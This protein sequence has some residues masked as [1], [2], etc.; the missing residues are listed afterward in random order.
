MGTVGKAVEIGKSN[1]IAE[2]NA[3]SIQ[4]AR[5]GLEVLAAHRSMHGDYLFQTIQG[6]SR[7]IREGL[8]PRELVAVDYMNRREGNHKACATHDFCDASRAM[9]ESISVV[10]S[11]ANGDDMFF[12]PSLMAEEGPGASFGRMLWNEGWKTVRESGYSRLATGLRQV[13][14]ENFSNVAM[15]LMKLPEATSQAF[16]R[17]P[18]WPLGFEGYAGFDELADFAASRLSFLVNDFKEFAAA[19]SVAVDSGDRDAVMNLL[20]AFELDHRDEQAP[21]PFR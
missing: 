2:R 11:S 4:A 3:W 19:V 14:A 10:L 5:V 15:V 1:V 17:Y 16:E 7:R 12:D 20:S 18:A 13:G 8:H 6:F 21:R 9:S